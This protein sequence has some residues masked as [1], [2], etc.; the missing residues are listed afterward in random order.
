MKLV[1]S[2]NLK[3]GEPM[4]EID[5]ENKSRPANGRWL[6]VDYG[7]TR[8][9]IAVSDPMGTIAR[10]LETIRWNGQDIG[11]VIDRIEALVRQHGVAGLVI[12]IPRRTDGKTGETEVKARELAAALADRTGLQP[13]L[14]D[15]R[16]TTVLAGRIMREVGLQA[17]RR[18]DIIDQVAAEIILQEYLESRRQSE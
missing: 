9:G 18:K 16:F 7:Q 17:S 13:V 15:E 5:Y 2:I 8:V 3:Q 14:L 11:R 12:G 6:A 4:T 10:G 1:D